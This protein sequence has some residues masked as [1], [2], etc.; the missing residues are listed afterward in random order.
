M[1][2]ALLALTKSYTSSVTGKKYIFCEAPT[3]MTYSSGVF[4]FKNN[5]PN[6]TTTQQAQHARL[7]YMS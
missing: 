5:L 2:H 3:E 1:V 6:G 4:S 7:P